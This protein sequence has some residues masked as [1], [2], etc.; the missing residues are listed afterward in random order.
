MFVPSKWKFPEKVFY[1]CDRRKCKEGCSNECKR[2]SDIAYAKNFEEIEEGVYEEIEKGVDEERAREA[3][4][5]IVWSAIAVALSAI[6]LILNIL[7]YI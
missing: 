6:A 2:T 5:E 7:C 3:K 4:V 1:I